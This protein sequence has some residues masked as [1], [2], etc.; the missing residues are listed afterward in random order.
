MDTSAVDA[1]V[2]KGVNL[3]LIGVAFLPVY[4]LLAWLYPT[5]D[6]LV[7]GTRSVELFEMAGQAILFVIF[8][9]G[10]VRVVYALTVVRNRVLRS[11]EGIDKS[12]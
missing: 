8:G 11:A 6:L 5:N 7:S 10:I 2:R 1:G 9:V 3:I 4:K 12:V